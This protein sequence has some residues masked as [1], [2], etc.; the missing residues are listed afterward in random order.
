MS[1]ILFDV[2]EGVGQ[3]LGIDQEKLDALRKLTDPEAFES[4]ETM[5]SALVEGI[6]YDPET[7]WNRKDLGAIFDADH[8]DSDGFERD[9]FI[10]AALARFN[11]MREALLGMAAADPEE[12]AKKGRVQELFDLRQEYPISNEPPRPIPE[13]DLED[14]EDDDYGYTKPASVGAFFDKFE[15]RPNAGEDSLDDP[16][17]DDEEDDEPSLVE[18]AEIVEELEDGDDPDPEVI[19]DDDDDE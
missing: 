16:E 4:R 11:N 1:S 10:D 18:E 6:G 19:D 13:E 14:D 9:R 8:E 12:T 3:G 15:K 5:A 2:L 7:H 17:E